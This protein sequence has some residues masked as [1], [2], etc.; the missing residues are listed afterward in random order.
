MNSFEFKILR[1]EFE[2]FDLQK[3]KEFKTMKSFSN[4]IQTDSRSMTVK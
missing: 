1:A 2:F 4:D 3:M